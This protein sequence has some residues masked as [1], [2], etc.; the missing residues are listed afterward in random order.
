MI[1]KLRDN[2]NEIDQAGEDYDSADQYDLV[3]EKN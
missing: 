2:M 3:D 1:A